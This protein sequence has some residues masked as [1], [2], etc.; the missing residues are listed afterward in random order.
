MNR[1]FSTGVLLSLAVAAL[2]ILALEFRSLRQ[3]EALQAAK[4]G[5]AKPSMEAVFSF[6]QPVCA[7]KPALLV[8]K[9]EDARTPTAGFELGADDHVTKPFKHSG[10]D[11]ARAGAFAAFLACS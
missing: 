4:A 11:G 10:A 2:W 1:Q 7:P 3:L 9:T 6:P 8:P 5:S